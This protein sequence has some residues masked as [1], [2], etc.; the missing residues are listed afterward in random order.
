MKLTKNDKIVVLSVDPG[1]TTGY[2]VGRFTAG[3]KKPEVLRLGEMDLWVGLERLFLEYFPDVAVYEVFKLYPYLAQT[4]SWSTFPTVE[5]IGVLKYLAD[6]Y[7][8]P[9]AGQGANMKKATRINPKHPSP[10]VRDAARH[11]LVYWRR[12]SD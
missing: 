2:F 11:A 8:V 5:V 1:E 6:K 3:E 7:A 12:H 10:H 4:Q 9:I